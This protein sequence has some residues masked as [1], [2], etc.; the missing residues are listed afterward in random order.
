MY[1]TQSL[2]PFLLLLISG[3]S[4]F[5]AKDNAE[6]PAELVELESQLKI[7]ELWDRSFEG[8]DEAFLK[9]APAFD[10]ERLYIAEPSGE[11][12]ALD[13]ETGKTLWSEDL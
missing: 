8:S 9:I 6:P 11:V 12:I 3:C 2:L 5:S 1:R 4:A 13:P 10:Y 7:Q